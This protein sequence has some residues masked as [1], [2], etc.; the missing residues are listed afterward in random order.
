MVLVLFQIR[1]C[2]ISFPTNVSHSPYL[3]NSEEMS[4]HASKLPKWQFMTAQFRVGISIKS[5][6]FYGFLVSCHLKFEKKTHDAINIWISH[7]YNICWC[8]TIRQWREIFRSLLIY[9]YFYCYLDY[10]TITW[11]L[12]TIEKMKKPVSPSYNIRSKISVLLVLFSWT[13]VT[14]VTYHTFCAHNFDSFKVGQG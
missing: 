11:L 6:S 7:I 10:M 14:N 12:H 2:Y 5:S 3:N 8:I 4:L 1:I 13:R 9:L